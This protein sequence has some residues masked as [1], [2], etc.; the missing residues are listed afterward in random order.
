MLLIGIFEKMHE[1]IEAPIARAPDTIILREVNQNGQYAKTEYF[2]KKIIYEKNYTILNVLL[3]TGRTHQIRVH[4][5]YINHT[6]LGD[7]LYA[8]PNE[9]DIIKKY[10][11]R[12]ALHAQNISF[13]H[14][15]LHTQTN[16]SASLPT[17]ILNLI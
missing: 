8:K 10:I 13:I 12:Q 17:D 4:M 1:I 2:V 11:L 6:L 15:I 7:D 9:I 3:H 16:I 14:P 5:S